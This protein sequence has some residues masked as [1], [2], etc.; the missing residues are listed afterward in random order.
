MLTPEERKEHKRLLNKKHFARW[1][2]IKKNRDKQN[3]NSL[4]WH[5]TPK[6]KQWKKEHP[7]VKKLPPLEIRFWRKVLIKSPS[8]CW[9]WKG[10]KFPT[11][12]GHLGNKCAH[13]LSYEINIG[14]I[15][16]RMCVCHTC[17]NPS[18]VNPNHLWLETVKDNM[19]DR[20]KKG[21]D[22]YSKQKMLTI[23]TQ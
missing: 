13:R 6:G 8:L 22:R 12:Y 10:L 11:G 7:Y 2:S 17:D 21:R 5:S 18:C 23:K 1:Y 4:K 19:R 3:K 9:E 15:P 16:F 14:K 20:D